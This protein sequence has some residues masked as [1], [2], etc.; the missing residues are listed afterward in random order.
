M[1]LPNYNHAV[2]FDILHAIKPLYGYVQFNH[3]NMTANVPTALES[4]Q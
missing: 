3:L 2:E 1:I 4:Y